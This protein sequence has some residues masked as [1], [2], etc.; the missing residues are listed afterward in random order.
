M[1]A[2]KEVSEYTTPRMKLLRF[3]VGSRDRWK[4]KCLKAKQAWKRQK[5]QV[6]AVQ[7]SREEWKA[8][9][10]QHRQQIQELEEELEKLKRGGR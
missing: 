2:S 3:F 10:K 8:L 9:A 7:K 6:R 4:E 1:L 5:N